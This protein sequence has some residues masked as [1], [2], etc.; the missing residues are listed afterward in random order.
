MC[1]AR[2]RARLSCFWP[3]RIRIT[4]DDGLRA[5]P[6]R[7]AEGGCPLDKNEGAVKDKDILSG[8]EHRFFAREVEDQDSGNGNLTL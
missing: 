5:S 1:E 7:T 4:A 2:Q 8:A 6:G 3:A